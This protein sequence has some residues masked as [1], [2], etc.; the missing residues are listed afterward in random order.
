MSREGFRTSTLR[1]APDKHALNSDTHLVPW[2]K[3]QRF[4]CDLPPTRLRFVLEL[5]QCCLIVCN[6]PLLQTFSNIDQ[7]KLFPDPP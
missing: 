7:I 6:P 3:I 5:A 4:P 1:I 2:S